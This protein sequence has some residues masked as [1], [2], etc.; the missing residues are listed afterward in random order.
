MFFSEFVFIDVYRVIKDYLKVLEALDKFL[1]YRF[2][3]EDY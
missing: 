1:N 2:F 3:L